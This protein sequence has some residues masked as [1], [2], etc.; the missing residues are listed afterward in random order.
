MICSK[1][2][3]LSTTYNPVWLPATQCHALL[4]QCDTPWREKPWENCFK[5]TK[6]RMACQM[7][8]RNLAVACLRAR[9]WLA[10]LFFRCTARLKGNKL[11]IHD[12]LLACRY[13]GKHG[14][15][16][17]L[18]YLFSYKYKDNKENHPPSY[19]CKCVRF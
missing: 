12:L 13:L 3:V 6:N 5:S 9:R 16:T 2:V 4:R 7:L 18:A 15:S 1:V 10:Q 17:R 19:K 11:T 14:R 8:V